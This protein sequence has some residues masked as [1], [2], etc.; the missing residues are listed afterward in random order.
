MGEWETLMVGK[1]WNT[2]T[3]KEKLDWLRARVEELQGKVGNTPS[4]E[5]VERA[6]GNLD[7]KIEKVAKDLDELKKGTEQED[8]PR[9]Y[10]RAGSA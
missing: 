6:V 3:D 2:M 1:T 8:S 5:E 9:Q 10:Q 4:N 7:R